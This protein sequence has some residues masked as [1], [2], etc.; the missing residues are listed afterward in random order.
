[1]NYSIDLL[2]QVAVDAVHL[3]Q[4]VDARPLDARHAAEVREQLLAP[5][6]PYPG[7]ALQLRLAPG[8]GAALAVPRDRETVRLVANVL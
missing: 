3:G 7:N 2:G 1:M 5:L 4:L 8:L 6:G